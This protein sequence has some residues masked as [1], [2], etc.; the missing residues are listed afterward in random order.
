VELFLCSEEVWLDFGT[1]ESLGFSIFS[2]IETE[3][4]SLLQVPNRGKIDSAQPDR[5]H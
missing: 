1:I 5:L 4:K 2:N 3:S